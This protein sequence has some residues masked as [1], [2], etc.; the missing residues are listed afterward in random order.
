[1]PHY[2]TEEDVADF[3][4]RLRDTAAEL[5]AELGYAGFT[6]R[7]LATRLN[8]SSMTA[9]R[10]FHDKDEI[11]AAVRAHAFSRLADRLEAAPMPSPSIA[12]RN[13]PVVV[14]YTDF[15]RQDEIY[16]R[17]MFDLSQTKID[18][19]PE[20]ELQLLRARTAMTRQARDLVEKG[21]FEGDPELISP[22]L[23]SML[24]GV[25][26][27]H[28]AGKL[29]DAEFQ[30]VLAETVQVLARGFAPANPLRVPRRAPIAVSTAAE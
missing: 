15:A 1:M 12:E 7:E 27:L 25:V 10:Y 13:F 11:L 14:A 21:V 4:M 16:Y 5:L 23:W 6:M 24:H 18:R 22:I 3:R 8:I 2:L 28:L 30:A 26:A 17:L 20:A 9:Y 19:S 29:Q